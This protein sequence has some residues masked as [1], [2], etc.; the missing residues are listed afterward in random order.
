[1][2]NMDFYVYTFYKFV[3]ISDKED[4]KRKLDKYFKNKLIRGTFLIANEGINCSISATQKD[5][6]D[7]VEYLKKILELKNFDI[8]KN[9]TNF[10]PFNRIKVRLKKEIVSLGVN[11][12]SMKSDK[13]NMIDPSEWDEIIKN[14]KV[15]LLDT[16]NIFE[17][18][19]GKF[20]DSI[21]PETKSFREFPKKF[22]KLNISKNA[23]IA[24]Y[25]TG[26]IRCEKASSYLKKV[27][28]KNVFQ[29]KG[30]I[31]NYLNYKNEKKLS[32]L[33]KGECFV[34]D[35]RVTLNKKLQRG[36]YIQ[37]FGCRRPITKVEAHSK[38]YIK[39]VCCPYCFSERTNKQK[40]NSKIRQIQI[41]KANSKMQSHTFM[42]IKNN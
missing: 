36:K 21:N 30:G 25:C 6:S 4:I 12:L 2:N 19:I 33:W 17:I 8:K 27:G 29:L 9:A 40:N 15:K 3:K 7:I 16:R 39:G 31:L 37:C 14:K 34:F 13:D 26:G 35:N 10:L 42:K 24:M 22:D 11:K 23:H 32:S 20:K 38:L 18:D 41:D 28:Y 1:M 5:L